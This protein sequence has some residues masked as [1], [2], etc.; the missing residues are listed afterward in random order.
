M[1]AQVLQTQT[2]AHGPLGF[3]QTVLQTPGKLWSG[4]LRVILL[5]VQAG[6]CARG[7]PASAMAGFGASQ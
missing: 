2:A 7:V 4:F 3:P 1:F 5:R 6:V